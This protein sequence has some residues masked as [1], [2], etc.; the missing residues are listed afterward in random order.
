MAV[1]RN[2]PGGVFGDKRVAKGS[3]SYIEGALRGGSGP[4]EGI[5]DVKI[6][7]PQQSIN[8]AV[9]LDNVKLAMDVPSSIIGDDKGFGG[10]IDN[11]EHSLKGSTA[12]NE[13][14]GAAG[15]VRHNIIPNH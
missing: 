15:K 11:L 2:G 1:D 10:G 4:S 8:T 6:N 12:E 3:E 14:V 7:R 9:A 13:D 5:E